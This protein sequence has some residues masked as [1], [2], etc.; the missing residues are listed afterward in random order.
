LLGS[1]SGGLRTFSQP[2]NRSVIVLVKS[3][4]GFENLFPTYRLLNNSL[5]E[6]YLGV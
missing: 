6:V 5:P 1:L 2:E 4:W 3:I